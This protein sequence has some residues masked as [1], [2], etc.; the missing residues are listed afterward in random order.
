M[1]GAEIIDRCLTRRIEVG[2]IDSWMEYYLRQTRPVANWSGAEESTMR[3]FGGRTGA[4]QAAERLKG[5]LSD[6][7][8]DMYKIGDQ[9]A[10]TL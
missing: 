1:L 4:K 3:G 10:K 8:S 9:L 6:E 2:E 7:D 5:A